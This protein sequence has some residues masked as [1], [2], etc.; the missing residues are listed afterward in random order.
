MRIG[1]RSEN[2]DTDAGAPSGLVA[3]LNVV[4]VIAFVAADDRRDSA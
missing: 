1:T 2:S 3:R 4:A